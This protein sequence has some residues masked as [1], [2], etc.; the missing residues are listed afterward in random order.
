[1]GEEYQPL[2]FKRPR[3]YADEIC[4]ESSIDQ[5]RI[6]LDKVPEEYREMVRCHVHNHFAIKKL[7]VFKQA[8]DQSGIIVKRIS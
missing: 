4:Q 2:L 7:Q 8:L 5:R 3:H 1:M 6:M